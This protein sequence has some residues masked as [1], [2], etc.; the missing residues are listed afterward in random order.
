MISDLIISS[1]ENLG[2]VHLGYC[3]ND[4]MRKMLLHTQQMYRCAIILQMYSSLKVVK[5]QIENF[6]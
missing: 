5:E 3:S 6:S 2:Q 4:R 1:C